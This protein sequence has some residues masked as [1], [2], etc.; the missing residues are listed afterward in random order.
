MNSFTNLVKG[1]PP[2][3]LF[4][5]PIHQR[6]YVPLDLSIHNPDLNQLNISNANDCQR[7]VDLIANNNCNI[8]YGGYLEK[9]N[10]YGSSDRFNNTEIRNIHLGIDF[11]LPE[12]TVVL[13]PLKGKVHS[14]ANNADFGN[15]GP[16]II[17]EH[18]INGFTFYTLYGHLSLD[19]IDTLFVGQEFN[20]AS[21]LARLGATEINVGYAP[22][23]HFQLILDIQT[24][25]GDY[26][27][28]CSNTNL[29]FYKDNCPN[30]NLLL[31]L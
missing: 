17:L 24:Y 19:S 28:V 8:P 29:D 12:Q 5:D 20:Q 16:T 21:F 11:W 15:Y 27:G 26:P 18:N 23:L 13:A 9:R 6:N 10:L 31:K 1:L 2:I 25:T 4:Q 3:Q 30:P 14:F 22:H 7:Y